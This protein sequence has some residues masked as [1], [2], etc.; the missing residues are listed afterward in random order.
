MSKRSN[1]PAGKAA[2]NSSKTAADKPA[3]PS[4]RSRIAAHEKP[5]VRAA[6]RGPPPGRKAA[7]FVLVKKESSPPKGAKPAEKSE[8]SAPKVGR[9]VGSG[10]S[11]RGPGRP[12]SKDGGGEGEKA[13][14]EPAQGRGSQDGAEQ[15]EDGAGAPPTPGKRKAAAAAA[16]APSDAKAPPNKRQRTAAAKAAAPKAAADAPAVAKE[17]ASQGKE[18]SAAGAL[19]VAKTRKAAPDSA[20]EESTQAS[21]PASKGELQP[22][23]YSSRRTFQEMYTDGFELSRMWSALTPLSRPAYRFTAAR[24][25]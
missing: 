2:V 13:A 1:A 4:V 25:Q 6:P 16:A 23:C 14:S 3:G 15:G 10:R 21:D 17:A 11:G 19:A 7:P 18:A 9:P 20:P 5:A 24:F 22:T 8:A 12:A